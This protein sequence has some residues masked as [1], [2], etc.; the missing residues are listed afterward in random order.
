MKI[1]FWLGGLLALGLLLAYI[2]AQAH[3]V[4]IFAWVEG[5]TVYT[6]SKF[7]G[8]RR[9]KQAPV[10]VYDM[11]GKKLLEGKTDDKGEFSFTVP[12]KTGLRIVLKAGMGHQAEWVVPAEEISAEAPAQAA[13]AK[14]EAEPAPPAAVP[15]M[16]TA[17]MQAAMEKALDNKLKPVIR[18]LAQA[19]EKEPGFKDIFG[20]IGY[21]I[22]LAGMA[23]F[24]RYRREKR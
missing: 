24:F 9:P 10:E 8:G 19:Q 13:P 12:Q 17:M 18:M 7:S 23:A 4:T 20:G 21:I 3:N 14:T 6:E 2:P 22:G 15:M 1:K 11:Q 5:D 16:D